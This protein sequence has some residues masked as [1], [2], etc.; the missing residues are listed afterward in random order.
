VRYSREQS[1]LALR[2]RAA[3]SSTWV[4]HERQKRVH[5]DAELRRLLYVA[6]TRA[7]E[8]LVFAAAERNRSAG[9]DTFGSLLGDWRD[10]ELARLAIAEP[11]TVQAPPPAQA[12]TSPLAALERAAAASRIAQAAARPLLARPSG[13]AES[14]EE[15]LPVE[16]EESLPAR[17]A[18]A[19]ELGRA[20]GS[21]LHDVLERLS[22]KSPSAARALL[23]P[24][25]A[26]AARL[27]SL[28]EE[29]V[30]AHAGTALDAFLASG[31][32]AA[33]AKVDVV[34]RELPLLFEDEDGTRWNGTI[35][36]LYRDPADRRLVVA[37]YKSE[38]APER[39]DRERYRR[40]LAVYV[41]GVAHLFPDELAPAAELI[42]LRSGQR[43]RL[44]LESP[45]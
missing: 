2:T 39:A 21:A 32:P 45:A 43:E 25:V 5:A 41:R 34:G 38:A 10:P 27:A 31:L 6:A 13:V 20:A 22:F 33:L 18:R 15:P 3:F 26:R 28:P 40:Q 9:A 19:R 11:A 1:A 42:W 4:E 24:A 8:R 7:R 29:E 23:R 37:D 16:T 44:P 30:A 35:D 36:L 14:D 12:G 17:V